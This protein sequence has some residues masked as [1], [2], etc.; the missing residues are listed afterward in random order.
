MVLLS[1]FAPVTSH[2]SLILTNHASIS[3]PLTELSPHPAPQRP[4]SLCS[5]TPGL[6]PVSSLS[7]TFYGSFHP[8]LPFLG[9]LA[10]LV[11]PSLSRSSSLSLTTSLHSG[12]HRLFKLKAQV[13]AS[14]D[15]KPHQGQ[16]GD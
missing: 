1:S 14:L 7:Y 4:L 6:T 13:P 15:E 10:S 3:I 2:Q 8:G 5:Y 9:S 12:E 16:E 11:R